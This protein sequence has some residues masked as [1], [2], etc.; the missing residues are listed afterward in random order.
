MFEDRQEMIVVMLCGFPFEKERFGVS[1]HIYQISR[2]FSE[3]KNISCHILSMHGFSKT[4]KIH[5]GLWL[6]TVKRQIWYYLFPGLA[7]KALYKIIR[8]INPDIVHLQGTTFPYSQAAGFASKSFPVVVTVHG[9]VAREAAIERNLIRKLWGLFVMRPTMLSVIKRHSAVI[10]CS[11]EMRNGLLKYKNEQDGIFVIPNGFDRHS[12]YPRK[13]ENPEEFPSILYI[14]G[15]K[16]IK[17]VDIL[18]RA[19]PI[20][21]QKAGMVRVLIAGAGPEQDRLFRLAQ[22]LKIEN[23]I[24]FL[25]YVSGEG[26]IRLIQEAG[27]VVLPSLFENSPLSVLEAMGCGKPIIASRVGGIPE[28]VENGKTGL[29]FEAGNHEQ[30]AD[31][32]VTLIQDKALRH[33]YGNEAYARSRQYSWD[34]SADQIIEVYKK[35]MLPP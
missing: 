9:D 22:E 18:I 30:L 3:E 35:V 25:G 4:T 32:I 16:K 26:K 19:L 28:L 17:G 21:F 14:G 13:E 23:R 1:E 7:A 31:Q 34:K 2:S 5:S 24:H 8:N 6:H 12:F 33:Q 27:I 20:V 11:R 15:L 29:L 10:V